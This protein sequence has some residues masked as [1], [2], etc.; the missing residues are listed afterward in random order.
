MYVLRSPAC[1]CR[2]VRVAQEATRYAQQGRADMHKRI[3]INKDTSYTHMYVYIEIGRYTIGK[4]ISAPACTCRPVRVAQEA[5]R[6]APQGRADGAATVQPYRRA[7][8][9]HTCETKMRIMMLR[10]PTR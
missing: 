7:C 3:T 9:R 2:P 5:T 1:T 4:Y 6:Y 8:R 10:L